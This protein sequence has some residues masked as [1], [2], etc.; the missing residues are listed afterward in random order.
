MKR[1]FLE[2]LSFTNLCAGLGCGFFC[3]RKFLKNNFTNLLV[4]VYGFCN[5]LQDK[6]IMLFFAEN[7]KATEK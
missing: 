2:V 7:L 4:R 1:T 3:L 5:L 6:D